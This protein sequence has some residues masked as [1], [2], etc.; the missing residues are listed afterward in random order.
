MW[1]KVRSKCYLET[2][3]DVNN[4]P[5]GLNTIVETLVAE[6]VSSNT[7]LLHTVNLLWPGLIKSFGIKNEHI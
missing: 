5:T 1:R 4:L 2:S 3:I 6:V 7:I